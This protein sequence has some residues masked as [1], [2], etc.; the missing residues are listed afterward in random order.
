MAPAPTPTCV[1]LHTRWMA[2]VGVVECPT[3]VCSTST[4]A[5]CLHGACR[6]QRTAA[7]PRYAHL[8]FGGQEGAWGGSGGLLSQAEACCHSGGLQSPCFGWQ[9]RLA[10]TCRLGVAVTRRLGCVCRLPPG[11]HRVRLG[12]GPYACHV[13]APRVLVAARRGPRPLLSR[14]VTSIHRTQSTCGPTWPH[15]IEAPLWH[16]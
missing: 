2:G 10:V 8:G 3:A 11:K 1:Y 12:F 7:M 9:R 6:G 16:R 14:H 5:R 15:V 4:P 13:L